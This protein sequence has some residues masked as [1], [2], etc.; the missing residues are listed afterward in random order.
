MVR[1]VTTSNSIESINLVELDI[2]DTSEVVYNEGGPA[3]YRSPPVSMKKSF[4][5]KRWLAFVSY[6]IHRICDYSLM[7]K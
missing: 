7:K 3:E 5:V 2:M 1:R 6:T 4:Y